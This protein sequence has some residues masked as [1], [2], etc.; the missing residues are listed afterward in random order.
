M[1]GLRGALGLLT[2]LPAGGG[3]H[4]RAAVAW[5][6]PVGLL[7]G[8]LLAGVAAGAFELWAPPATAAVVVAVW[9]ILT[10]ALHL[11]GAADTADAAF[12]PVA[13]VRRLEILRDVHHGTFA[14]AAVA[15]ILLL[16]FGALA[17]LGA[18]EAAALALLAPPIARA[19]LPAAIRLFAQARSEGM[20][21]SAEA[22]ASGTAIAAALAIAGVAATAALGWQG[23]AV[24]GG[25]LAAMLVLAAWLASRFGGL[26]GDTYGALVEIGE[27]T[28]LLAGSAL[29]VRGWAEPFPVEGWL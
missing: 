9:V 20:G 3:Y 23:L 25:T 6:A 4:P 26:T 13:R 8:V 11:D 5:F 10:G 29:L 22:G 28:L 18:A 17:G 12:A 1:N 2:V 24:A 16:K 27:V 19:A 14:V 7:I 15:V 21:A